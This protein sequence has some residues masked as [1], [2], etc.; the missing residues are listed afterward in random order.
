[1]TSHRRLVAARTTPRRTAFSPGQ[2]PP[3]VRTPMRLIMSRHPSSS[4]LSGISPAEKPGKIQPAQKRSSA[5]RRLPLWRAPRGRPCIVKLPA[6]LEQPLGDPEAVGG[7][8]HDQ[9]KAA[10]GDQ[11]FAL[12]LLSDR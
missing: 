1:M 4:S 9:V 10:R 7:A 5:S 11:D 3:L 12:L 2:S 8:E 6:A